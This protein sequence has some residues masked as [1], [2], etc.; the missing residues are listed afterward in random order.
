MCGAV[1]LERQ[2]LSPVLGFFVGSVVAVLEREGEE[3]EGWLCAMAHV[4]PD[5]IPG[6]RCESG[7]DLE[8]GDHA[9]RAVTGMTWHFLLS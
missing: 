9:R 8:C 5:F 1:T 2:T 4:T 7:S 6:W 3:V